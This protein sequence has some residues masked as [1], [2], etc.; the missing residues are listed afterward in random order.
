M[1]QLGLFVLVVGGRVH[2]E[3]TKTGLHA[4][5]GVLGTGD[6]GLG[7]GARAGT[8]AGARTGARTGARAVAQAAAQENA[9]PL[10]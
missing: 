8:R 1:L 10:Q 9:R 3:P 2:L 5:A 6:A 7:T 4:R